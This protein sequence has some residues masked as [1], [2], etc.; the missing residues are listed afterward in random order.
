MAS[1]LMAYYDLNPVGVIDQDKWEL[2]TPE[3]NLKF[4]ELSLYTPLIDWDSSPQKTG[5]VTTI[6]TELIEGDVDSNPIPLTANFIDAEGVDSRFRKFTVERHGSKVQYHKSSDA[7]TMWQKSG[8]RDWRGLLR[9]LLG[10]NVVAKTEILS[11][12]AW[13][14]GPKAYWTYAG[15]KTSFDTITASDKFALDIVNQW[16]LRLGNT[17]SPVIPGDE[18]QAKLA[19]L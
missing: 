14:K 11:R 5:A 10:R 12:N 3:V 15:G 9:G 6:E 19:I 18:A 16:D 17:G 2:R 4:R 7:Y 8:G 1:D 13:F